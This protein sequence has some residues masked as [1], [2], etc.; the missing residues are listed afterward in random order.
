MF[1]S[2][3]QWNVV[4]K[5]VISF[6]TQQL[7]QGRPDHEVLLELILE[8]TNNQKKLTEFHE[9]AD[10][11]GNCKAMDWK[12]KDLHPKDLKNLRKQVRF[13]K[14]AVSIGYITGE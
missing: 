14:Y 3:H 1:P 7:P 12:L 11:G 8:E 10:Q 13:F 2:E 4:L 9:D 6:C 5:N